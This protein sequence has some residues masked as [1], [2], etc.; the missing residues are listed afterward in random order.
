MANIQK[1]NALQAIASDTGATPEQIAEF[2]KLHNISDP[3][4]LAGNEALMNELLTSVNGA[5]APTE[6]TKPAKRGR[7]PKQVAAPDSGLRT[8]Q[9]R[10]G[11]EIETMKTTIDE[12]LTQYERGQAEQ[13]LERF[14]ATPSNIMSYLSEGLEVYR[15]D[16]D[17]FREQ[18]SASLSAAFPIG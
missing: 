4:E 17:G 16:A 3:S 10:V 8:V 18:L 12:H 2:M 9:S 6:Q 14:E 1:S 11:H 13:L 7:K 15:D 5:L